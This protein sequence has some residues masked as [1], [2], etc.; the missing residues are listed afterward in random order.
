[1]N[2]KFRNTLRTIEAEKSLRVS[3]HEKISNIWYSTKLQMIKLLDNQEN[4]NDIK[5]Q[6]FLD[7]N[8]I[9][10][11]REV[12]DIA[13]WLIPI[14]EFKTSIILPEDYNHMIEWSH[15][16]E[17]NTIDFEA[18]FQRFWQEKFI[19]YQDAINQLWPVEAF[20]YIE[21]YLARKQ[22]MNEDDNTNI[23][24][25]PSDVKGLNWIFTNW[26]INKR[27]NRNKLFVKV[28]YNQ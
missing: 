23:V 13:M 25:N 14:K 7:N 18:L 6:I 24:I 28:E 21:M 2:N 27:G 11:Q 12:A 19:N 3:S 16:S 9:Q 1:M 26:E 10:Q 17:P 8:I 4:G 20:K 15:V 22:F 5:L